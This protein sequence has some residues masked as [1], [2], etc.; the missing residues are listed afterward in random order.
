MN[1]LAVFLRELS[2]AATRTYDRT[3]S[4]PPTMHV[5]AGYILNVMVERDLSLEAI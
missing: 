4:Q 5:P 2:S 1:R 3:L